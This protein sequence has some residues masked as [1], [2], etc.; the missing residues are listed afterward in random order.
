MG[1]GVMSSVVWAVNQYQLFE[2]GCL[3]PEV[4]L[5]PGY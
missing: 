2:A 3:L 4:I 1:F 5:L